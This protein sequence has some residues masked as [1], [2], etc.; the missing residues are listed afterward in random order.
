MSAPAAETVPAEDEVFS[1]LDATQDL[2]GILGIDYTL[3][4]DES[5]AT[6]DIEGGARGTRGFSGLAVTL[7]FSTDEAFLFLGVAP[8]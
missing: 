7:N 6:I 5:G 1:P 4:Q 2:L 3:I 8:A